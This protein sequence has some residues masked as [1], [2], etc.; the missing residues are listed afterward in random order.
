MNELWGEIILPITAKDGD[1]RLGSVIM[2]LLFIKFCTF[3]LLE[4]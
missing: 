2:T 3:F 4:G 1:Q